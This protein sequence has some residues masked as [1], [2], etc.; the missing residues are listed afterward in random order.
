ML[1]TFP[2]RRG[3]REDHSEQIDSGLQSARR[4]QVHVFE[5]WKENHPMQ[6]GQN[7]NAG[8]RDRSRE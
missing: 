3:K 7:S 1:P 6:L 5:R 4:F 8:L 2:H